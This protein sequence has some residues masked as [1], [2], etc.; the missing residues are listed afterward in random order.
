MRVAGGLF[1][2]AVHSLAWTI[3]RCP[4]CFHRRHFEEILSLNALNIKQCNPHV[5]QIRQM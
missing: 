5:E 2:R 4:L 1:S 3:R